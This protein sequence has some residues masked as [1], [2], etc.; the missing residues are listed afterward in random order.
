MESNKMSQINGYLFG[1]LGMTFCKGKKILWHSLAVGT[2]VDMHSI[3]FYGN[4]LKTTD[5]NHRDGLVLFP[6]MALHLI[7]NITGVILLHR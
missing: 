1:N 3:F 5:G 6:G 7:L 4:T 2:E